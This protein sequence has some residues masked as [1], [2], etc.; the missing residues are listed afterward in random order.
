MK[1]MLQDLDGNLISKDNL[2]H[3]QTGK[4][5]EKDKIIQTNKAELE[6][7][8]KRTKMQDHK[9]RDTFIYTSREIAGL[10]M[11]CSIS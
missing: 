6:R 4:L 3:E 8:E 7:L 1:A 2:I 5:D 10:K 9:V 11:C